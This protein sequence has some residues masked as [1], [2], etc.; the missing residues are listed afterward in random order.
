MCVQIVLCFSVYILFC[1]IYF[2]SQVGTS[3]CCHKEDIDDVNETIELDHDIEG[4]E[5]ILSFPCDILETLNKESDGSKPNIEEIEVVNLV[6]EG[7]N[8][9]P[10]KIGVN[11]PKDLK[12]ELI[13]LL[14]EFR[15]IFA[16]SNQD[17]QGL[18]TE[19][20]MHRIPVKPECP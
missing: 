2:D 1:R 3:S 14:K 16:W 5:E 17:M 9:K 7:E 6:D 18:N 13:A 19:I 15:E 11:Y 4:L 20:V 12:H 10:T 8:E